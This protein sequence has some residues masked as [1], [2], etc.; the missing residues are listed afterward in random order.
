MKAIPDLDFAAKQIKP[1]A[2]PGSQGG[3]STPEH[4]PGK[5]QNSAQKLSSKEVGSRRGSGEETLRLVELIS[6]FMSHAR[7]TVLVDSPSNG[8]LN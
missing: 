2:P 5:P 7:A 8:G 3:M 4:R 6:V 1:S